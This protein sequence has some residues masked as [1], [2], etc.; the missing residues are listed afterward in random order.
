MYAERHEV[1]ITTDASGDATGYTPAVTG[2]VLGVRYVKTDYDNG[3]DFTITLEDTG[4]AVL[5]G[6]NINASQSFYPRVVMDDEAGAD[7][8]LAA[9]GEEQRVPV[10]AVNDRVKIVVAQG[11]DTQN[12]TLPPLFCLRGPPVG[13]VGGVGWGSG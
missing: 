10:V 3:V 1:A 11:G 4:E 2:R 8:L 13:G 6:T 5:T 12:R 9:A 7:A